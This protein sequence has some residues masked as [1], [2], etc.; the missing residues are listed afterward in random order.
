MRQVQ[1]TIILCLLALLCLATSVVARAQVVLKVGIRDVLLFQEKHLVRA[2]EDFMKLNP[3]VK[4]ELSTLTSDAIIVQTAAGVG[5]DVIAET[6]TQA[7]GLFN[8]GLLLELTDYTTADDDFSES[9]FLPGMTSAYSDGKARWSIPFNV[10]AWVTT[11]NGEY[12]A[13]A[14]LPLPQVGPNWNWD[15]IRDYGKKLTI[16]DANGNTTRYGLML[17]YNQV[18][19]WPAWV[20]LTYQAGGGLS[21]RHM[22]PTVINMKISSVRAALD[23]MFS[24]WDTGMMASTGGVT[25]RNGKAAINMTFTPRTAD[26]WANYL[27]DHNKVGQIQQPRGPVQDGWFVDAQGFGISALSDKPDLAWQFIKFLTLRPESCYD[28]MVDGGRMSALRE[29]TRYFS[30]E[31]NM[32]SK[33]A[34]L[35]AIG[36]PNN[37]TR[38]VFQPGLLEMIDKELAEVQAQRVSLEAAL[39][40]IQRMADA[41]LAEFFAEERK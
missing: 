40:N 16:V 15:T 19:A 8:Q 38:P 31:V 14:G 5:P 26:Y 29:N 4:I 20:P 11:Y 13:Q 37:V 17:G 10:L 30:Q 36:N 35:F 33:D 24:L 32:T 34:V 23:F 2:A 21:G 12:F 25:V 1:K 41:K 9:L 27:G 7:L 39:D 6:A 22:N 28:L 3:H 18:P